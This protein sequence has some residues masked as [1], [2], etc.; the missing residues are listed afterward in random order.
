[1][2][3]RAARPRHALRYVAAEQSHA[4]RL[5]WLC[6]ALSRSRN[7]FRPTTTITSRPPGR[8]KQN[9]AG[10]TIPTRHLASAADLPSIDEYVPFPASTYQQVPLPPGSAFDYNNSATRWTSLFQHSGLDD[11]IA[12]DNTI[13]QPPPRVSSS[14]RVGIE[15]HGDAHDIE[16]T[17]NACL[18]LFRW[19]RAFALLRQLEHVYKYNSYSPQHLLKAYNKCLEA[20][21]MDLVANRNKSNIDR[22]NR[23]VEVD[24]K[25]AGVEPDALTY[26]L[27][28][29]VAL[30]TM[31]GSKRDR[32]VRRYWEAAKKHDVGAEVASLRAILSDSDLGKLS[33][34]SPEMMF[35][36][37]A[38]WSDSSKRMSQESEPDDRKILETGQKGLGL[39]SLRESLGSFMNKEDALTAAEENQSGAPARVDPLVARQIRVETDA[40]NSAIKRWK[41]EHEKMAKLGV[42]NGKI[43]G[44]LSSVLW[45]WHSTMARK[46]T[47]ELE[48]VEAAEAKT[49]KT[50]QEKLRA[51]YG[52]FLRLLMPE[53][54]AALITISMIQIVS[55]AGI[56]TPIKFGKTVCELGRIVEMEV[57]SEQALLKV[58]KAKKEKALSDRRKYKWIDPQLKQGNDNTTRW[59]ES[60]EHFNSRLFSKKVR[61]SHAIHARVGAILCELLL[62]SSKI[63]VRQKNATTG[64]SETVSK[65]AFLR[66]TAFAKGKQVGVISLH[67]SMVE[68]MTREPPSHLIA[69]QLPMVSKPRPWMG[70]TEGG[71]LT[72]DT[73]FLRSK[74]GDMSQR[75][76]GEAAA[77]R[78]DLD[79]IFKGIDV[80]GGTGWK[81]NPAVFQV[82][83]DAWNSGQAIAN[84]P[85]A[86]KAFPEVPKPPADADQKAR[87]AYYETVRKLENERSGM[88]SNRCFQ[89]FQMEIAKAY[90]DD[91]FYLPH[92]VD[93]RGRAYPIPPYL[94]Q[95]GADNCRG[96]LTFAKGR[97]LGKD[98][99]RWLKIH[100][101]NVYGYDKASLSDRANFPIEHLEDVLD[102]VRNPLDGKRWWLTAEDPWQCLAACFELAAALE[103]PNPEEFVSHLAVHQDGSC[104]GLQHY[105]ALGGDMQGAKQVNLEPGDKPADVYTGVAE[106]VKAEIAEDAKAGHELGMY[107]DGKITRKI[108]KQT[109]MTN[110]YGVT[111]LGAVRQV[112]KQIDEYMPELSQQ[113]RSGAAGSYI[114]RKI[115]KALGTMFSGAHDIQ[116]WLGDCANRISS[117]LSPAQLKLIAER[118]SKG[119][120]FNDASGDPVKAKRAPVAGSNPKKK[121]L[122][123][124]PSLFRS[125]V[126]WT[127]PLK[128]P[129]VQPYRINK[130]RR[131]KTNLQTVVLHEPTVAD[132]VDKRKQLQAFPPNF[133]HS[134]DATH[135]ILSAL[136]ADEMGM[137]FTAVHDSFWTHAADV[138]AMNELLRDAFIR[139]HSEDIIGR[140]AAEFDRR[141]SG[142]MYLATIKA[143]SP[144]ATELQDFRGK[145]KYEYGA[146][147]DAKKY[148]ELVWEIERQ[149]LL[150]S[151][152]PEQ[153]AKGEAMVTPASIFAKHNGEQYLVSRDSLGQT[154]TGLPSSKTSDVV[155]ENAL[156]SEEVQDDHNVDMSATL[157][158]LIENNA[159]VGSE[160]SISAHRDAAMTI[161]EADLADKAKVEFSVKPKT[162]TKLGTKVP[163]NIQVWLPLVFREVPKKGDFDVSRLRD[164]QYFFS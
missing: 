86:E 7:E 126:I 5:P 162:T 121:G 77:S 17:L 85:P 135:M 2:L 14:H 57:E 119:L 75:D 108:V 96:L 146:S 68:I 29:K 102:S 27:K 101:S 10:S 161:D 103:A 158:P 143:K 113:R 78:G 88:H 15:I 89:S 155:L 159:L 22:I 8:R 106:L 92:N 156:D 20:M 46:I 50:S 122:H 132:A 30:A 32:T 110:V 164:S 79:Q 87:F 37:N 43:R 35:G 97:A 139:M 55:K 76:Y 28:I 64:V 133:V 142:H 90:L 26:A 141:Y 107:L 154:A 144:L 52:P 112:R 153:V 44:R 118:N 47:E 62:D 16:V 65:H 9:S 80:L 134:L 157:G 120:Y 129:V 49:K 42:D 149:N 84:L 1:M 45:Q 58:R 123:L 145:Q 105:A 116:Y 53:H 140:L 63:N 98:G 130:G 150:S 70:F 151:E 136:K 4:L 6:P 3:A 61:W 99:L 83:L 127:T 25:K 41:V 94:N 137:D 128:L 115:F 114:A 163:A 109:V 138:N 36:S 21:V 131:I 147:K 104:N 34:I 13:A 23:W 12:I 74:T 31:D 24:M 60:I 11:I 67:P 71:Y 56:G 39:S 148:Q 124:D 160:T 93:F 48:K 69:K 33:Q 73:P 59:G 117:S 111:F 91:T 51:E 82:M 95:M 152:N 100:L 72:S 125:S 40:L 54:F 38:E 81:I 19:N 66:E 18:Q